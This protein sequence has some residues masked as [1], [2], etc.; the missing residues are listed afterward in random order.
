MRDEKGAER[1]TQG[2]AD[3][4]SAA[5]EGACRRASRTAVCAG[6]EG[7]VVD[8]DITKHDARRGKQRRHSCEWER[9][10]RYTRETRCGRSGRKL[11]LTGQR[12]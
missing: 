12:Q 6:R 10:L 5:G 4:A 8:L 3:E 1:A 9:Q 7:L 2:K 11:G